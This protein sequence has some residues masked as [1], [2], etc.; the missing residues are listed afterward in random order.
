MKALVL[1]SIQSIHRT[2]P[3]Y[4]VSAPY[5]QR[6]FMAMEDGICMAYAIPLPTLCRPSLDPRIPCACSS[7]SSAVRGHSNA[8]LQHV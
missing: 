7:L 2:P 4:C 1:A 3:Y 5:L 6:K 8:T